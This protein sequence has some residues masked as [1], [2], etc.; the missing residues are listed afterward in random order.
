MLILNAVSAA[1]V[2][3]FQPGPEPDPEPE[4]ELPPPP[5]PSEPTEIWVIVTASAGLIAAGAL[6]GICTH[7]AYSY[8]VRQKLPNIPTWD[9]LPRPT[10][11]FRRRERYEVISEKED[12]P[13]SPQRQKF[14]ESVRRGLQRDSA[15]REKELARER[16]GKPPKK[17][18]PKP[19]SKQPKKQ[20]GDTGWEVML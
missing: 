13:P 15:K 10:Q 2:V 6:C 19:Q 17:P 14:E 1:V 11:L 5:P 16:A 4:P 20:L 12:L 18:K 8:R 3:L 9:G 7:A